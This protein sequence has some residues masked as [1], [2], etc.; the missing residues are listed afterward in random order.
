MSIDNLQV[1]GDNKQFGMAYRVT[2]PKSMRTV[3]KHLHGFDPATTFVDIGCGK[4]CTLLVASRFPFRKIVGVE[5]ADELCR[6]AQNNVRRYTGLQA[7]KDI[8]VLRMDATEFSFP[9]GPLMVYFFNPFHESVMEKVLTNLLHSLEIHPRPVTLVCDASYH[10]DV[11]M[12]VFRPLKIE[13]ICGFSIYSNV[14]ASK[15]ESTSANNLST[16][17]R[18]EL[19]G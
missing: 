14:A 8:S 1:V 9:D 6:I 16:S 10:R 2:L 7:C 17:K 18:P 5:F 3:L 4:G 15:S 11:V 12:Q 13:R 19:A